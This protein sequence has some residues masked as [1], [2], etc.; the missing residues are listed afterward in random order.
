MLLDKIRT[1][2]QAEY[3]TEYGRS[4]FGY[5]GG[6]IGLAH[7]GHQLEPARLAVHLL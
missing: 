3:R 2:P 7:A 1:Q 4:F 5:L 6:S